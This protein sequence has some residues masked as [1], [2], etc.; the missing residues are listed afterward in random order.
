M[1]GDCRDQVCQARK[2]MRATSE[3]EEGFAGKN[4]EMCVL[5]ATRLLGES[6]GV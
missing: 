1:V 6:F 5:A 2:Q 3:E 4:V